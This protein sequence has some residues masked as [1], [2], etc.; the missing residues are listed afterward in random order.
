MRKLLG[1][2]GRVPRVMITATLASDHA[3]LVTLSAQCY[4]PDQFL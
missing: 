4:K 1:K 2:Q 3:P